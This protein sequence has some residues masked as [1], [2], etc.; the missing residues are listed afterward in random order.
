MIALALLWGGYKCVRAGFAAQ[1]DFNERNAHRLHDSRSS[2]GSFAPFALGIVLIVA[3]A[4]VLIAALVPVRVTEKL[5]G[6]Q[7]NNTL[8]QNPQ[9]GSTLGN[10][11]AFI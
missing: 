1:R 5:L 2:S 11:D 4:P 10:W 7:T 6:R 3:G 9:P 8:W